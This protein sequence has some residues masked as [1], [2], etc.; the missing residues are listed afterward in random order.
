MAYSL[1]GCRQDYR[2][3]IEKF[4]KHLHYRISSCTQRLQCHTPPSNSLGARVALKNLCRWKCVKNVK[5]RKFWPGYHGNRLTNLVERSNI[6]AERCAVHDQRIY[7]PLEACLFSQEPEN[8][9]FF[10]IWTD[11]PNSE[12]IISKTVRASSNLRTPITLANHLNFP[13]VKLPWPSDQ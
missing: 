8:L 9:H 6:D 5:N 10:E 3:Y 4:W 13:T 11:N 12:A 7:W 1:A 2:E